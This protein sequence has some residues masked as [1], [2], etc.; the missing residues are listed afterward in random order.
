VC[1]GLSAVW[2]GS[3]CT[4]WS[5][6]VGLAEGDP[7]SREIIWCELYSDSISRYETDEMFLH[8]ATHVG[9]NYHV[10]EFFWELYLKDSSGER[11]EYLAFYFDFIVF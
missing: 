1:A 7:T 8:L 2:C 11:L 10:R 9:S 4:N 5:V 3:W 6:G